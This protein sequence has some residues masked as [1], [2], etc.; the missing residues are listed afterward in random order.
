MP[1][2]GSPRELARRK[3]RARFPRP[4]R[5]TRAARTDGGTSYLP[6]V[7]SA[8]TALTAVVAILISWM[9]L[10]INHDEQIL[11]RYTSAVEQLG[12]TSLLTRTGAVYSLGRIAVESSY[13]RPVIIAMLADFIS[14]YAG[15]GDADPKT[16][17]GTRAAPPLDV[18]AAMRVLFFRI[19]REPGDGRLDLRRL[20]L[21][22]VEMPGADL[23]CVRLDQ[24]VIEYSN[25]DG[26]NLTG[27]SLQHT[28]VGGT[29]LAHA[30]FTRADA[31][32]ADFRPVNTYSGTDLTGARLWDAEF[33]E[34][35]LVGVDLTGADLSRTR[36]TRAD[37]TGS[38][39]TGARLATY[40]GDVARLPAD[41]DRTAALDSADALTHPAP[42][43]VC[44]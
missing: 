9:T 35:K 23:T 5:R 28:R 13:D 7:S 16:C 20:C 24:S 44:P 21:I 2:S 37:L 11:A 12:H 30:V 6:R 41:A 14:A 32:R 25:F 36:L 39:L 8:L 29:S 17:H 43:P 40:L 22:G 19:P 4:A 10:R 38:E 27:A 3:L 42:A 31:F 18:I 33:V 1:P 26:A 15:M 34:A